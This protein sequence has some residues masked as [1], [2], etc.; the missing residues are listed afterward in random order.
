[1]SDLSPVWVCV[2][3]LTWKW[4]R[5]ANISIALKFERIRN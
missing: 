1:M 3:V 2:T 4:K 5:L